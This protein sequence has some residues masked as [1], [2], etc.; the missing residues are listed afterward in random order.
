MKENDITNYFEDET[1]NKV[2]FKEI[3]LKY[4]KHWK[5][6]LILI[7]SAIIISNIYLR[8]KTPLYESTATILIKNNQKGGSGMSETSA[9]EDLSMFSEG[10]SIENE[11]AILTSR[12]LMKNVVKKLN[13]SH[14]YYQ[15]GNLTGFRKREIYKK[16]PYEIK[17]DVNNS[18]DLN[19]YSFELSIVILNHK[20]IAFEF[21]NSSKK[22][23]VPFN[24]WHN[25][26]KGIRIKFQK[27]G[28]N[29]KVVSNK[30]RVK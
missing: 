4:Y 8:Y 9:F 23:V 14:E 15:I 26:K 28:N 25:I 3:V 22:V 5:L 29:S 27:N 2:N 13:L 10:N 30:I 19:D 18:L 16:N 17:F 24:K 6:F 1:E 21:L 11:K 20:E 12:S 7:S